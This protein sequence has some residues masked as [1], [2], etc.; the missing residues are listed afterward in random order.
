MVSVIHDLGFV[1]RFSLLTNAFTH[2]HRYDKYAS[3]RHTEPRGRP[4]P[5]RYADRSG[6]DTRPDERRRGGAG[7]RDMTSQMDP[8]TL[9]QGK[10]IASELK[11]MLFTLLKNH[12][13]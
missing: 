9:A 2:T 12:Q 8:A 7:G 3:D 1:S 13:K 5:D 11:N 10:D 4:M 6:Y